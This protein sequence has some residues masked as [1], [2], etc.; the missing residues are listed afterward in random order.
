MKI[1]KSEVRGHDKMFM[2]PS[3][4]AAPSILALRS[5]VDVWLCVKRVVT[6]QSAKQSAFTDA[7]AVP[8]SPGGE[9]DT[10]PHPL[11]ANAI[12]NLPPVPADTRA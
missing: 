8:R 3:G 5:D 9:A 2:S 4:A 12:S 11:T 10:C 7:N 6:H 1:P